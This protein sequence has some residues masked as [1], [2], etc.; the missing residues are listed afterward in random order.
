MKTVGELHMQINSLQRELADAH[1]D[2]N[3]KDDRIRELEKEL[4]RVQYSIREF[5]IDERTI[6]TLALETEE[7]SFDP[8]ATGEFNVNRWR[9][10]R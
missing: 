6:E 3:I 5:E 4:R 10:V 2:L 9:N 7:E 1:V 8:Y